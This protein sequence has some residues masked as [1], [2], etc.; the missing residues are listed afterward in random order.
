M[1]QEACTREEEKL[2]KLCKNNKSQFRSIFASTHKNSDLAS[3]IC[4]RPCRRSTSSSPLCEWATT[5]LAVIHAASLSAKQEVIFS[6]VWHRD[7][8]F[9][10]SP[11]CSKAASRPF[12]CWRETLWASVT[13]R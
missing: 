3:P 1:R 5:M 2:Y 12:C 9:R 8:Y 11:H 7:V 6:A 4:W 13:P 10:N